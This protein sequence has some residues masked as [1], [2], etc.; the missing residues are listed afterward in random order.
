MAPRFVSEPL[1]QIAEVLIV[2]GPP[3]LKSENARING[4][5]FVDI[6]GVDVGSYVAAAQARVADE[7]GLP[8][9]YSLV[10]SGQYEYMQKAKATLMV[11]LILEPHLKICRMTG[12]ARSAEL[13]KMILRRNSR[14]R[15]KAYN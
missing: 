1:G 14:K 6:E 3:M 5:T 2:D 15:I 7:L 8:A 12:R 10:W 4:W 13:E 9:G 11:V